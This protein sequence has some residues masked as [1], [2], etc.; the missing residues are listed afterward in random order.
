[1]PP[2]RNRPVIRRARNLSDNETAPFGQY[3]MLASDATEMPS[4]GSGRITQLGLEA[5][6]AVIGADVAPTE[7]TLTSISEGKPI[8]AW[9]ATNQIRKI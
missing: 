6:E 2:G 4:A 1:V 9:L 3:V 5:A 8:A 7:T